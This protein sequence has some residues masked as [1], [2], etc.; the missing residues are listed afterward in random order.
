MEKNIEINF[1]WQYYVNRY[2]DLQ[3]AHI[4]TYEKAL[5]HWK[6]YGKKEGRICNKNLENT[7]TK[8]IIKERKISDKPI[9][10]LDSINNNDM[11]FYK[12]DALNNNFE[13]SPRI[14]AVIPVYG[15]EPLLR[16]TIRRLY[17]K[18]KLYKVICVGYTENEKDVVLQEKGIWVSH[19]N[20]PLGKKWNTGFKIAQIYNPD[21]ILFVGSSDWISSDWTNIAYTYMIDK[22]IGIVGKN[23]FDM[24]DINNNIKSC[25][26]LGY[27]ENNERYKETI[28]IGRLINKSFLD[29]INFEP[30]DNYFDNSMDYCMYKKCINNKF[31]IKILEN[32]S[33]FLSISCSKWE[34]KHQFNNHY[35]AAHNINEFDKLKLSNELQL[36]YKRT[37]CHTSEE[38]IY[39]YKEFDELNELISDLI[40]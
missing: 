16:Y 32:D 27:P 34:N 36:I 13:T 37:K 7:N 39:I 10:L 24:I 15:R 28:G 19:E 11:E 20:K 40:L 1:D 12:N 31:K 29:S 22:N 25:Y 8:V 5:K 21:A 33:I 4:N 30:F 18:N 14:I 23:R 2:Q 17:N 3:K 35:L 9:N 38:L 6:T 26:W